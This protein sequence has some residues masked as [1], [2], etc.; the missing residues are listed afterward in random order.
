MPRTQADAERDDGVRVPQTV[1]GRDAER[2]ALRRAFSRDSHENVHVGGPHGA[3]KTLL[4]TPGLRQTPGAP[5]PCYIPCREYRTQYQ[6]L[7]RLTELLTGEAVPAGYRT[8]QLQRQTATALRDRSVVFV[9]DDVEFL[10]QADGPDLLYYLSRLEAAQASIVTV[11]ATEPDLTE[12]L[13][14]RAASSLQPQHLSV[15]PYTAAQ[16]ARILGV[17]ARECVPQPVT[18]AA[19]RQIAARTTNITLG[20][21][22]LRRAA[23]VTDRDTVLAAAVVPRLEQDALHRYW[24]D[25][26]SAFTCHHA[27][28]LTAVEQIATEPGRPV[29]G[30]VYDRYTTL[31]RGR[32]VAPVT[33]RRVGDYLDQLELLGLIQVE[34][35]RGGAQGKTRVIRLT[36][37]EEL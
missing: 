6:V 28:V 27:L 13:E 14:S 19:L 12:A 25:A 32:D 31:C 23:E 11:S 29:T 4:T 30:R 16:A 34:H 7:A 3:G 20:L 21:H 10:L 22:W 36:S 37:V 18:D 2:A 5:R 1:V 24:L 33:L 26:L 35:L 9:L 17:H 15:P 8:T